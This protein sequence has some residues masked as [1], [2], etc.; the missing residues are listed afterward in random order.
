MWAVVVGAARHSHDVDAAL[1][2][3]VMGAGHVAAAAAAENCPFMRPELG[4]R[5]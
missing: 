2:T 3:H 4:A 1:E 5:C